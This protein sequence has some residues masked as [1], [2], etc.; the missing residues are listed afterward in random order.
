MKF[1]AADPEKAVL[2]P[3]F[4]Q[5]YEI[6]FK[7]ELFDRHLRLNLALFKM[8][9]TDVQ[10]SSLVPGTTTALIQNAGDI[11]AKGLELNAEA[12]LGPAFNLTAG[13]A[14]LLHFA[15]P[16]FFF[17]TTTAYDILRHNGVELGKLDFLGRG[18]SN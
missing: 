1:T 13:I 15:L 17:H 5:N 8:T 11:R 16:N 3:S 6:G 10:L 12:Q 7:S 18:T 14:Y 9:T 4:T 2:K